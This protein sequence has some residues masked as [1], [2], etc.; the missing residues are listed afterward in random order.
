MSTASFAPSL[1]PLAFIILFISFLT[2][3]HLCRATKHMH[4]EGRIRRSFIA[5]SDELTSAQGKII[6]H[7]QNMES[8]F[9]RQSDHIAIVDCIQV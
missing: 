6:F 8:R 1:S 7:E 5:W 4:K 9:A 3:N 2:Q